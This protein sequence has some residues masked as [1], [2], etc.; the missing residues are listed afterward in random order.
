MSRKRKKNK[1]RVQASNDFNF[2]KNESILNLIEMNK[3]EYKKS[4]KKI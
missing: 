4:N 3:Q 1:Q 2:N